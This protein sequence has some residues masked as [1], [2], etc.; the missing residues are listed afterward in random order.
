MRR[1]AEQVAIQFAE[2]VEAVRVHTRIMRDNWCPNFSAGGYENG[3]MVSPSPS[4][5]DGY[6][7]ALK[8]G[9]L[10]DSDELCDKCKIRLKAIGDRRDARRR[11]GAAKRAVEAVGKLE[12]QLQQKEGE[13]G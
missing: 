8:D 12:A 3:V 9:A 5:L 10:P 13:R 7:E 11:L 2:A 1:T 4:C 6:F